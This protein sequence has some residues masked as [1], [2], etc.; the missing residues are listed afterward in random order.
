MLGLAYLINSCMTSTLDWRW[1]QPA[2]RFRSSA[3][4]GWP[5]SSSR[6]A[7]PR[8]MRS[9][10]PEVVTANALDLNPVLTA[11]CEL[12]PGVMGKMISIQR[13]CRGRR[14]HRND[15]R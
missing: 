9:R 1:R 14:R 12:S 6:A 13:H 5:A 2:S 7:T 3:R 15:D 10:Q 11:L 4:A 8:P